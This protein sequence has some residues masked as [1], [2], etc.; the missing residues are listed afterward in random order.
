MGVVKQKCSNCGAEIDL[1]A[2]NIML[3]CPCCANELTVD[4]KPVLTTSGQR[5]TGR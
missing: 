4:E 2:E 1:Y 3:Y 5:N